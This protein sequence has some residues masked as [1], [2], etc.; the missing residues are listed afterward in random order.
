MTPYK[1]AVL[2]S[3]PIQYQAPLFKKLAQ[4]PQIDLTVYFC[5]HYGI[6]R[7]KDPQFGVTFKWDIPLLDGYKSVFL[8]NYNPKVGPSFLRLI[9]PG[10]ISELKRNKYNAILVYGWMS[11]TNWFVFLCSRK[12]PVLLQAES[13][14]NQELLKPSWKLKVKKIVLGKLFRKLKSFLYIGEE[15]KKFYTFYGVPEEKLSF[16][17][18]A[19][20]N[21]RFIV[22][23]DKLLAQK[24]SLKQELG[25]NPEKV[26]VLFCGKLINKKRPLDLLRAYEKVSARNKALMYVGDGSLKGEITHYTQS[27]G[28][29]DVH[30]VGFKNQSELSTYYAIADVFVLP[31]TIGETWGLVV[32]EAMCFQLPVIVSDRLGCG[33]DLVKH[34]K[35]GFVF[36][37]GDI[38]KLADYLEELIISKEKR[39][40]FGRESFAIVKKHHY[41]KDIEGII[42]AIEFCK[43][44]N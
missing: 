14:L 17:P 40:A 34:N 19:V 28:I 2:T 44:S 43:R 39:E 41:Q 15:N 12:T 33:P 4:H 22:D 18:Y 27:K 6:K 11:I 16:T 26:V 8:K 23:A 36:P 13:P 38:D 21:D 35:N 29:Q 31:S 7:M 3:H 5:C 32:N 20:D 37:V 9:N 10:I 30:M 24:N 25:I 1:L 42:A